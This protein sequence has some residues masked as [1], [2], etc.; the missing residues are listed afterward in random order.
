[1]IAHKTT[2]VNPVRDRGAL[3]ALAVSN[4]VNLTSYA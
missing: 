1:M 3:R 4:G 2:P